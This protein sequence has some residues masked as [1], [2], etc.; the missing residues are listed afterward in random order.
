MAILCLFFR[1]C[2][3]FKDSALFFFNGFI[4]LTENEFIYLPVGRPVI[5]Q[6]PIDVS[7]D[8]GEEVAMTC[9]YSGW[10]APVTTIS[11]LKDQQ[12]ISSFIVPL[13]GDRNSTLK[14]TA[15][16]DLAG[17]YVCLVQ[18]MGHP[19]VA[20]QPALLSVRGNFPPFSYLL[21]FYRC[22]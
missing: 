17:N 5:E 8:E 22:Q 14:L 19:V 13:E 9:N 11:W 3:I 10:P 15:S 20:S 7:V 18:T 4:A 12:P 1:S 6:H 2:V 21:F 16:A